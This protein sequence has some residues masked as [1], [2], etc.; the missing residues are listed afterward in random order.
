VETISPCLRRADQ[1]HKGGA[2]GLPRTYKGLFTLII[3]ALDPDDRAPE[4][5]NMLEAII[6]GL[7][8][9]L[10]ALAKAVENV[11]TGKLA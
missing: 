2:R 11:G 4:D 8:V 10:C 5:R 7:V 9:D 6:P 3:K 1:P